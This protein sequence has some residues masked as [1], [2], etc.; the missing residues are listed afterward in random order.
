ME[1]DRLCQKLKFTQSLINTMYNSRRLLIYAHY[2]Q[3]LHAL[4]DTRQKSGK[5]I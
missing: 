2:I 4:C 1:G 3:H 5:D